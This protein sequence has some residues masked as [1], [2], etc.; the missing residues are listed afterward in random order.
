[1]SK[2][3]DLSVNFPTSYVNFLKR[4][5]SAST[6]PVCHSLHIHAGDFWPPSIW[7]HADVPHGCT[8]HTTATYVCHIR[9]SGHI[10]KR[11]SAKRSLLSRIGK[12]GRGLQV[13][14]THTHHFFMIVP[15]FF[16]KRGHGFLI[17]LC[18]GRVDVSMTQV[19]TRRLLG[20]L[21]RISQLQVHRVPDTRVQ[22]PSVRATHQ[23]VG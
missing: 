6:C 20:C 16:P 14:H 18:W 11:L 8:L 15:Y 7:L 5:R 21:R 17:R 9:S 10:Y 19:S 12:L 22:P 23:N 3:H 13:T 1:M 4:L 2:F